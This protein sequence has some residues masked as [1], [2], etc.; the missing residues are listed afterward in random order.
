MSGI[1]KDML[2][3][4]ARDLPEGRD[5]RIIIRLPLPLFSCRRND[6]RKDDSRHMGI[7]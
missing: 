3:T 2:N 5:L 4:E 6:T 1:V 7:F